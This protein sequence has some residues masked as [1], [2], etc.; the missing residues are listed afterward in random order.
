MTDKKK[1]RTPPRFPSRLVDIADARSIELDD[2]QVLKFPRGGNFALCSTKSGTQLWI[3]SRKG[4]KKVRTND[5]E[6]KKLFEKFTGFIPDDTAKMVQARP[7]KMHRLGRAAN[8]VYR[9]DK[10]SKPGSTSDYIHAFES[11][12][13]VSVDDPKRPSIVAIRGGKLKVKKEGITG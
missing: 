8:I 3:I 9:S 6:G 10:F 5:D 1:Q 11:Y 4:G 13:I 12:P 7:R 2:G